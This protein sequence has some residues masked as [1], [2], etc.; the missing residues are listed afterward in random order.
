MTIDKEQLTNNW[1]ENRFGE[2]K[3]KDVYK[4]TN[5]GEE[6]T[7][8]ESYQFCWWAKY[9]QLLEH[10]TGKEKASSH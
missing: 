10:A 3:F 4:Q 9:E 7:M 1:F 2:L 5:E 6:W 8:K